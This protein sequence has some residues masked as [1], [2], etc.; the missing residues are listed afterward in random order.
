MALEHLYQTNDEQRIIVARS[1]G[2]ANAELGLLA[3][4]IVGFPV[5]ATYAVM[6]R[7]SK[8][9]NV[10]GG[11]PTIFQGHHNMTVTPEAYKQYLVERG[12]QGAGQGVGPMQLTHWSIQD[13]ADNFGGSY[14]PFIN[15]LI[16]VD[17]LNELWDLHGDWEQ[18]FPRW[19]ADPSYTRAMVD[20]K[21]PLWKTRMTI[22]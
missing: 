15:I 13:E 9:K 6:E 4:R 2:I 19:N 11:D 10:W 21:L 20:E 5:F 22:Q 12:E 1:A 3:S 7:E 16:G 17:F 18:V 8:G 14:V